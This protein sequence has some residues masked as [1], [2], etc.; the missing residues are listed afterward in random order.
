[1][2]EVLKITSP[3][4]CFEFLK[5]K[6]KELVSSQN[7]YTFYIHNLEIINIENGKIVDQE[8]YEYYFKK[9]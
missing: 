4:L 7:M 3:I 8:Y 1:M 5:K 6:K 2:W 9:L